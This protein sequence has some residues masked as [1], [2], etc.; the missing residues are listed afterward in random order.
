MPTDEDSTPRV[1]DVPLQ[2]RG[3]WEKSTQP[4]ISAM[5]QPQMP[6]KPQVA[7]SQGGQSGQGGQSQQSQS[8][9]D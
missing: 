3:G 6:N 7:Q 8:N 2:E 1:S 5:N 4:P 9:N